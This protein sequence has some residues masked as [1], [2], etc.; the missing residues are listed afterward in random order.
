FPIWPGNPPRLLVSPRPSWPTTLSPQHFKRRLGKRKQAMKPAD[1]ILPA[2][3]AP[4]CTPTSPPSPPTKPPPGPTRSS[5]LGAC[6]PERK[7]PP[8][9]HVVGSISADTHWPRALQVVR[10]SQGTPMQLAYAM[11]GTVRVRCSTK[12]RWRR[13]KMHPAGDSTE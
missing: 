10:S 1:T 7:Q 12:L 5:V 9:L 2:V 6:S 11:S 3:A 4:P 13:T 8:P